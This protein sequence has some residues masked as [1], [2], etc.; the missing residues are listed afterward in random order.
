MLHQLKLVT[1]R[2]GQ[3]NRGAPHPP[4]HPPGGRFNGFTRDHG[5]CLHQQRIPPRHNLPR[6]T[7]SGHTTR[8]PAFPA[9]LPPGPATLPPGPATLPP[10]PATRLPGPAGARDAEAQATA[11]L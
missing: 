5:P 7:R 2:A 3:E 8:R 4:P 6:R 9:T 10:G 1:D 11:V